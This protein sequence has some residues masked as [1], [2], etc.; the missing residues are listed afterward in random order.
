[1]QIS[2]LS[3]SLRKLTCAIAMSAAFTATAG[4]LAA[5]PASAAGRLTGCFSYAGVR[6]SGLSTAIEYQTRS[7]GWRLLAVGQKP[8]N[9]RGCDTWNVQGAARGWI[10][11]IRAVGLVPRWHGLFQ[12]FTFHDA[13]AGNDAYILGGGAL[14]FFPLPTEA[15]ST[16]PQ[17]SSG[18]NPDNWGD[19]TNTWLNEMTENGRNCSATPAM[20]VACYM[21]DHGMHGDVIVPSPPDSDGDGIYDEFD[22][23]PHDLTRH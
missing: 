8:T 22:R 13:P 2:R 23:Y 9:S 11:R 7:G 19:L 1:M 17:L 21:D 10:L 14:R 18:G 16:P 20:M 6:Y 4:A 12:G 5:T 3:R 15:P